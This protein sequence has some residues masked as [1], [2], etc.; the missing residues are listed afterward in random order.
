MITTIAPPDVIACV[1]DPALDARIAAAFAEDAK[2]ADV[3]R[4][5]PEVEAA[6]G[7]ADV[8]AGEARS[9]ALAACRT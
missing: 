5:L 8:V 9:R 3:R 4:L 2:S 7:A 6:A 1:P